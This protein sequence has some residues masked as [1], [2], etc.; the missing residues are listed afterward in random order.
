MVVH[1]LPPIPRSFN[2]ETA[3]ECGE[4]SSLPF[5]LFFFFFWLWCFGFPSLQLLP[6]GCVACV[7]AMCHLKIGWGVLGSGETFQFP[8]FFEVLP[9]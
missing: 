3:V 2:L 9:S 8:T 5:Q 1:Q 7:A 4:F 6:C